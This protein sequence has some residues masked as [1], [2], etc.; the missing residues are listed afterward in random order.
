MQYLTLSNL[1]CLQNRPWFEQGFE[2][3]GLQKSL[4]NWVVWW[5]CV[6]TPF[7]LR[8]HTK[9]ELINQIAPVV[10]LKASGCLYIIFLWTSSSGKGFQDCL[11]FMKPNKVLDRLLVQTGCHI[12]SITLTPDPRQLRKKHS[13]IFMVLSQPLPTVQLICPRRWL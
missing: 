8:S 3:N 12:K 5:L 11:S 10:S 7:S 2:P 4:P 6:P 9:R 13:C 1:I